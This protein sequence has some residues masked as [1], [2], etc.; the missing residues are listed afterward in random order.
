MT[1]DALL[2]ADPFFLAAFAAALLAT[3]AVAG[4]LAGLLGV[5]GGIVIVPVLFNLFPLIGIPEDVRMHVAVGTSL[6]TIIP[7]S[8]ISARAH[9]RRGGLDT[10]LFRR[11]MPAVLV[12]VLIGSWLGS[13]AKG[14]VL[15]LIFGVVAL[16]VA[17]NM[18]LRPEGMTLGASLPGGILRHLIGLVIGGFSVVMG[19]GGGT[20]SVPILTAF[21]YPIRRAVGTASALGLV[22][23]LPGAIAFILAGY[24]RPDLPPASLGYA[25]LLGFALIVPAT[26]LTAPL[27][28]RLAHTISPV[29][30]RR[31]FALFLFLTAARMFYS[32]S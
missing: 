31:A 3:G 6:A 11:L 29:W 17:A 20:L 22:I 8:I 30:L 2:H 27:G 24:G 12:G 18:A 26:M 4:T 1:L 9:Y 10:A 14:E 21:N 32:L 23:G 13:G 5:G 28:A 7:T 19:I 15:T 16:L 25:N